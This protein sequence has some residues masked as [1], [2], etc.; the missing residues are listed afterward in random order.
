MIGHYFTF[1]NHVSIFL[2]KFNE[3]NAQARILLNYTLVN[4]Y[5]LFIKTEIPLSRDA[6]NPVMIF[7]F[8]F[9]FS[10]YT[11]LT[12]VEPLSGDYARLNRPRKSID[13][14]II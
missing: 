2:Y 5:I 11:I 7:L 12:K 8:F 6:V 10:Q 14:R 13:H 1:Y 4:T 9:L 3:L